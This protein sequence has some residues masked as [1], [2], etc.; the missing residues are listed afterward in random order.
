MSFDY[1]ATAADA[2]EL[3]AEFGQVCVLASIPDGTYDPE[4]GE[5]STSSTPHPVTAAIFAYPQRYIDGTLIRTGDKRA[6]VSPVGLAVDPKPGDTLTDAAGVVFQVIDAK[7]TAP[8]GVA[9]LW[10][11][12]VRK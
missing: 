3:L 2:D 4:E 7:A 12:Q 6:L 10:T 8:A 9:V 5:A 1:D 11:L